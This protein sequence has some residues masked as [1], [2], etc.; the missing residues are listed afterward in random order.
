MLKLVAGGF[1]SFAQDD[2][3]MHATSPAWVLSACEQVF[4]A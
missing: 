2:L 4:V 1:T 3:R